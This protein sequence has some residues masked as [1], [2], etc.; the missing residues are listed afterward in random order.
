MPSD[1]PSNGDGPRESLPADEVSP[2]DDLEQPADTEEE[3]IDEDDPNL[4]DPSARALEPDSH[5][6]KDLPSEEQGPVAA[7]LRRAAPTAQDVHDGDSDWDGGEDE[8]AAEPGG[9]QE[10]R[11]WS[12]ESSPHVL[13]VELKR[14]E[15]EIRDALELRDTK[16]KRKLAGTRRW[17]E[18]QE[19]VM[20]WR[21]SGRFDE[22]TLR[23]L[24]QLITRRHYLFTRLRFLEGTRPIRNP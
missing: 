3:F 9:G 8:T 13:I 15:S 5:G 1:N 6:I 12:N 23:R 22:P 16:R 21:F 2:P 11:D 20:S 18:L 14:I 19:D 17:L 4:L 10:Q 24:E 7:R